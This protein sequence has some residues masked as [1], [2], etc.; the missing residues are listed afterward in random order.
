MP[1]KSEGKKQ[2]ESKKT[3]DN[4]GGRR[5]PINLL[6]DYQADGHY[7]FDFCRDLGSGGVFIETKTPLP[8]GSEVNLTFT[9][10][11]S[12]ETL[13]AKGKVIWVQS[14]IT[15]RADLTPGM[16][17]QFAGFTKEQRSTLE[18]FISR[19]QR[20]RGSVGSTEGPLGGGCDKQSA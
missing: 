9:L 13:D 17:V 4:R 15:G 2:S 1:R 6:V 5:V 18:N 8:Q 19:Y 16:G 14:P 10:P 7:L 12:K 20:N 3:A 11:D